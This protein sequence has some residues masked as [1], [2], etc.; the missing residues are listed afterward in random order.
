MTKAWSLAALLV[1]VAAQPVSAGSFA[2]H[3]VGVADIA[4]SPRPK[5]IEAPNGRSR[6][7]A[8]FSDWGASDADDRLAI[9]LGGDDHHF[10]AGPNTE[11]LWAPDS[12]SLAV[13]ADDGGATGTYELTLLVKKPKGRHWREIDVSRPVAE[14][15]APRMRC[16]DDEIPNVAAVGWTSGKRV[17]VVAQVP[18]HSSCRNMGMIAGYIVDADTGEPLMD[19]SLETLRKRYGAMLGTE[20][21]PSRRKHRRHQH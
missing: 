4:G 13:T 14:L 18:P 20:L 2:R 8:R 3:S 15:F 19:V 12:R 1:A 10:P 17:I 16:D 7:I 9:F 21:K 11:L 5:T 6:A